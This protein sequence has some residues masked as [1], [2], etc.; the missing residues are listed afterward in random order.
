MRREPGATSNIPRHWGLRPYGAARLP[1][2]LSLCGQ[3]GWAKRKAARQ[4]TTHPSW[5]RR[6]A[7]VASP[8]CPILRAG[9]FKH[10]LDAA[11]KAIIGLTS[12]G[13]GCYVSSHKDVETIGSFNNA[14]DIPDHP[15]RGEL[16]TIMD[17]SKKAADQVG[18][19]MVFCRKKTAGQQAVKL[20]DVIQTTLRTI[21]AVI[22]EDIE[23]QTHFEDRDPI[24]ADTDQIEL[25]ITNL[26]L[27]ARDAISQAGKIVIKT[28]NIVVPPQDDRLDKKLSPGEYV[29]LTI[30]D[31]GCGISE[32]NQKRLFEP[33]FSTKPKGSGV[34]LGLAS[35]KSLV[36]QNKG[37]IEFKS[38]VG[39]G[40]S[41][42]IY[43]PTT[44][45]KT[46]MTKTVMKKEPS[47][48]GNETILLV[49]DEFHIRDSC[50]KNL[51][52]LGYRVIEAGNGTEAL[53]LCRQL[54][55]KVD[56]LF[57]DVIMPDINGYDLTKQIRQCHPTVKVLLTSGYD[58]ETIE[59]QNDSPEKFNFINKPYTP[60]KLAQT[61]RAIL[62]DME[63]DKT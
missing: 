31:N 13:S 47:P 28:T 27:N 7:R 5:S 10:T 38:E 17:V 43:F 42:T 30:S 32:E 25:I 60:M 1:R 23:L 29:M 37:M 61:I 2:D 11:G 55:C 24:M 22:T 59:Q 33:Y 19:L 6:G 8:R 53:Q 44:G 54:D 52:R 9:D 58:A 39:K 57:S 26:F 4:R 49:E 36:N 21:R 62:D 63:P 3:S 34:G 14:G 35:V 20:S 40:T 16:K 12:D 56:L 41:F 46:V 18:H 45:E 15:L 50:V 51:Q 48:T